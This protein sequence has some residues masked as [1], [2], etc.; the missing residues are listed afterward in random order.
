MLYWELKG[1]A[2]VATC[3]YH[4]VEGGAGRVRTPFIIRAGRRL[5]VFQGRL[6]VF[7]RANAKF[8]E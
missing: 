5:F 7:S 1:G 8:K 2:L 6:Q 4:T 3:G